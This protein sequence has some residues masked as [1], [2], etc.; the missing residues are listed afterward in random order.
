MI[1]QHT[2]D[3][4]LSGEKTQTRRILKPGDLDLIK[5]VEGYP[6]KHLDDNTTI[7]QLPIEVANTAT[8]TA[9][10]RAQRRLW[11]VGQSIAVQPGRGQKAVGRIEI[12]AIRREDVRQI[13]EADAIAEGFH[14][15]SDFW[16]TWLEMHDKSWLKTYRYA[17]DTDY[18]YEY[19]FYSRP[20]DRYQAWVLEFKLVSTAL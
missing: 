16:Y 9:V 18:L 6:L 17:V 11:Y 2:I 19:G 8:I 12:T 3:K 13:S 1:F 5:R 14:D 20:T 4:V 7:Q 15:P 10:D